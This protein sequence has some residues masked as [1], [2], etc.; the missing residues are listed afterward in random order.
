MLQGMRSDRLSRSVP[1]SGMTDTSV[2]NSPPWTAA[3]PRIHE[4]HQLIPVLP[5][6]TYLHRLPTV[7]IYTVEAA[8]ANPLAPPSRSAGSRPEG[9]SHGS[10]AG[11]RRSRGARP[12]PGS[13]ARSSRPS[14]KA[15][16]PGYAQSLII[17]A[18]GAMIRVPLR[19]PMPTR[20]S[21]GCLLGPALLLQQ[22]GRVSGP[23][24]L[25]AGSCRHRPK[26]PMAAGKVTFPACEAALSTDRSCESPLQ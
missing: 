25:Q 7:Y 16:A 21:R 6:N 9:H 19:G 22:Q 17:L 10:A 8:N 18:H 12:R 15:T 23:A 2:P 4:T 14:R 26:G 5:D 13:Q 20:S 3:H 11:Q 1:Q 24:C